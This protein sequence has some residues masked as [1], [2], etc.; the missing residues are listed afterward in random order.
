MADEQGRVAEDLSGE[1][2]LERVADIARRLSEAES[3]DETLQRVVDLAQGFIDNC[4]GA[5]LMFLRPGGTVT[6][7]AATSREAA[8]AD[9]AQHDTGEGPC[10]HALREHET[11]TIDDIDNEQRWPDWRAKTSEL[12]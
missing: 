2:A 10:L 12:G 11:V 3:L 1:Q 4:D 6:T 8:Q 7:P 9:L 5:T